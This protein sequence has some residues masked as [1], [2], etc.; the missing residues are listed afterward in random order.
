MELDEILS[1]GFL[2]IAGVCVLTGH[3]YI[4]L[5]AVFFYGFISYPMWQRMDAEKEELK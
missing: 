2:L 4:F 5:L 3:P 1:L